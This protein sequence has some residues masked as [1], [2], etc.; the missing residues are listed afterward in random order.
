MSTSLI[1]DPS[2]G[3]WDRES[4]E[5][6]V[7]HSALRITPSAVLA[8]IP[9]PSVATH[10]SLTRRESSTVLSVQTEWDR[11]SYRDL[12]QVEITSAPSYRK[13]ESFEATSC[14]LDSSVKLVMTWTGKRGVPATSAVAISVP[15]YRVTHRDRESYCG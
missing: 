14:H 10:R 11:E 7:L 3:T 1:P 5:D 6:M 12:S 15:G 4:Y 13:I 8:T 2:T 9:A